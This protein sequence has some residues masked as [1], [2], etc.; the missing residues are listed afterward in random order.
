MQKHLLLLPALLLFAPHAPAQ[1]LTSLPDAPLPVAA[2]QPGPHSA[3][4]N[5]DG[6][7]SQVRLPGKP[8]A[9][10]AGDVDHASYEK[11]KWAQ[12]VDPGERVPRLSD[13]DKWTFWLHQEF[14]PASPLPAFISAGWGQLLD[15]D[16][17]YG[18]DSGAFGDRLGTAFLRQVTMRFFCSSMF[19]VIDGD[20][21]RYFRKASGGYWPRAGWAAEQALVTHRDSGRVSFNFS[22]V[23][24]H[25]AASALTPAYY[26][27]SSRSSRVV[28]Q[29]W[30][31][32]IAGAAG[33]NLFLEFWPDAANAWHRH[34]KHTHGASSGTG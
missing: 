2:A 26:P 24:G 1:A 28:F 17:K 21:P 33:N 20:D 12:Y 7:P 22:D 14:R 23:F 3:A 6:D 18:T 10:K 13:H 5:S 4:F 29:T 30:A 15:T 19:P 16:P 11:R 27:R 25:L 32:S 8:E 34:H 9:G 31:T